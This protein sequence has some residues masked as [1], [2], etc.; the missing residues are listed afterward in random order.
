MRKKVVFS[1]IILIILILVA[2]LG[3]KY[4]KRQLENAKL[5]EKFDLI[6]YVIYP[7]IKDV[8]QSLIDMSIGVKSISDH[9]YDMS[10]NDNYMYEYYMASMLNSNSYYYNFNKAWSTLE[11]HRGIFTFQ[12]FI[13]VFNGTPG[14]KNEKR[15]FQKFIDAFDLY[16][17]HGTTD[18]N[19]I[20]HDSL[21]NRF[22][23]IQKL[24]SES[25]DGLQKYKSD[26]PIGS[27]K[28]LKFPSKYEVK[29][30]NSYS[31]EIGNGWYNDGQLKT[32]Y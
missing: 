4:H 13:F 17:D 19:L 9:A 5:D 21:V 15:N 22:N 6:M 10:N 24:A 2:V 12:P 1:F 14:R 23:E 16:I 30:D 3:Y 27:W 8:A 11:N 18:Y 29:Y 32:N 25:L 26:L 31:S 28:H 20:S 7:D